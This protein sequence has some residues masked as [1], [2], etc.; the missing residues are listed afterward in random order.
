MRTKSKSQPKCTFVLLVLKT[1]LQF[2][3]LKSNACF[4]QTNL[5]DKRPSDKRL[6]ERR[7][8]D[9][10]PETK[11]EPQE[12]VTQQGINFIRPIESILFVV[13]PLDT[14]LL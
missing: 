1:L 4:F 2:F 10:K 8:S 3:F 9:T 14:S 11:L 7:T 5:M 6:P 12:P 13:F